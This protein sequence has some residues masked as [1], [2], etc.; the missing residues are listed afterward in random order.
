MQI[1]LENG[2][3]LL[4]TKVYQAVSSKVNTLCYD[5]F[6]NY[7]IQKLLEV[8]NEHTRSHLSHTIK[9]E[10]LFMSLHHY[11][12]RVVQKIIEIAVNNIQQ[13]QEIFNSLEL[14]LL[15]L[16]LNQNG[17]HI[18]QKIIEIFSP[19]VT[20]PIGQLIAGQVAL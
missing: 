10:M 16:F 4:R 5:K 18:A 2:S 8:G 17:N 3:Q 9:R 15:Q 7:V 6:G 12:C 11:A 14:H 19:K 1:A 20:I 13:Q